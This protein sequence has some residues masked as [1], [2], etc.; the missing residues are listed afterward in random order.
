MRN[1]IPEFLGISL[2]AV[3]ALGGA[4][5]S[6]EQGRELFTTPK[7]GTNGKS[8]ADCHPGGSGL[9]EAAS[10]ET[11]RLVRIVNQCISRPLAGKPVSP[12]S[13]EMRSL[14]MYV[15]TFAPGSK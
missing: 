11:E 14:V 4:L 10:F 12:D 9:E 13:S 3:M 15:R 1:R 6:V 5:P 7:L 8:C 2:A